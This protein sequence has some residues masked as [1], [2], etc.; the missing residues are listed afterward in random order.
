[1]SLFVCLKD[2]FFVII[3]TEL[4]DL[5]KINMHFTNEIVHA[6]EL[7]YFDTI[8][9]ANSICILKTGNLFA[10]CEFGNQYGTFLD[11][12]VFFFWLKN[13]FL[14]FIF[15]FLNLFKT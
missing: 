3:Q 7:Q 5:L 4:G 8:A 15:F 6:I 2:L 12:Y 9:L 10:A 13:I 11:I 14:S 1:M